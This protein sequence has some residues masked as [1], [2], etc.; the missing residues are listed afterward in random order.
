MNKIFIA[1][2]LSLLVL[3]INAAV[4]SGTGDTFAAG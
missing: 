3:K 2:A 4:C 1:I